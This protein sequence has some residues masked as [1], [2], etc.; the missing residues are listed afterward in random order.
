MRS[1]I[2]IALFGLFISSY[3][4]AG[5]WTNSGA[6][7]I[8]CQTVSAPAG[9]T[10]LT[11]TLT[12]SAGDWDLYVRGDACPTTTTYD[13]RPYLSGTST[14]VCGP[15]TLNSCNVYVWVHPYTLA[16]TWT[17]TATWTD[18][19]AYCTA[20]ATTCDERIS[21]ITV[22]TINNSTGCA[23][24]SGGVTGYSNYTAQST[25]MMIGTG[26][27]ISITNGTCYTGDQCAVWVD[28]NHD[29]S[30]CAA[31]ELITLSGGP[32]TFTG[33]ITPPAGA[34]LGNT[35]MRV[36]ITYTGSFYSCGTTTYGEVEDYTIN[37]TSCTAPSITAQPSNASMCIGGSA[38]FSVTASGTT[39]SYQWKYW[40]GSSYVNVANGT[41]AGAT[42]S[43]Q[44]TTAMTVSGITSAATYTYNCYVSN[45]C[46]NVTSSSAALTVNTIPTAPTATGASRCGAGTVTLS[47]GG[48]GSGEDYKWYSASSGG[49]PLQ[50]TGANYATP[51][52]T[53][54]TTYYVTKYN[55]TTGC[56]STTRTSAAATINTIPSVSVS[57]ASTAICSGTN[58]TLT[59]SG[60]STYVWSPSTGLNSTTGASVTCSA[61]VTT[62]YTVT[63]T[64]SNS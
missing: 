44:T 56:E 60:A 26:Y 20:G 36:R 63:G 43:N 34:V 31:N 62:T 21:N 27:P 51:S 19:G 32:C 10:N 3:L 1:K 46:G 11:F 17:I 7:D 18:P 41:P 55:T 15:Y 33:T 38:N 47:A 48:A 35:R 8:G 49:S 2:L 12:M 29:N 4:K 45:S 37:V 14:E 9:T 6:T 59:A 42:Y 39:L 13:C 58:T 24:N 54:T 30:F 61:A 40:N 50:T 23:L 5:S 28:W 52:F 16:G 64:G 22:G 25:T 53:V 57:P